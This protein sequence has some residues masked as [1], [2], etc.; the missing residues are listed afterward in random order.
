[1]D[2]EKLFAKIGDSL[3]VKRVFGEPIE[4]DGVTVIPVARVSGGWGGGTGQDDEGSQGTGGGAGMSAAPAGAFLIEGGRV[5][6][7]PAVDPVRMLVVV[8]LVLL[9]LRSV[10]RSCGK[11]CGCGCRKSACSCGGDGCSCGRCA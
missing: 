6:W 7:R 2:I 8:L 1:M 5:R 4:R 11:A 9:G 10:I 3:S